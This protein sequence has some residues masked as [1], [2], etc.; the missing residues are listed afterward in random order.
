V[1]CVLSRHKDNAGDVLITYD[2][3]GDFWGQG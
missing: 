1:P 2:G 3:T